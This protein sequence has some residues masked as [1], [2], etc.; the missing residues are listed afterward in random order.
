MYVSSMLYVDDFTRV[1][2][3]PRPCFP[4]LG[5]GVTS[6]AQT[7]CFCKITSGTNSVARLLDMEVV[8]AANDTTQDPA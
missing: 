3:S 1:L 7:V 5:I 6:Y 4:F 2:L 8:F